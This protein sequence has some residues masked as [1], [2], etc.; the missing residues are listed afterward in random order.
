MICTDVDMDLFSKRYIIFPYH[1]HLYMNRE[2]KGQVPNT[3]SFVD[4]MQK[5]SSKDY[6]IVYNCINNHEDLL[7]NY[8]FMINTDGT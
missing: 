4:S 2:F 7:D 1:G 5:K 8:T 3:K 6:V